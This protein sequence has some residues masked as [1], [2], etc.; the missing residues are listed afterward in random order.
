M[1]DD[2][3]GF[4]ISDILPDLPDVLLGEM[5]WNLLENAA[6]HNPKEKKEVWVEG[7]SKSGVYKL[8]VADDGPGLSASRKEAVF[9][10]RKHGGGVGLTLVSQM[11]RKYGGSIEVDDRVEGSPSLGAKFTITL[12]KPKKS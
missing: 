1:L 3:S 4:N 8:S 7:K 6:R 10:E 2:F 9:Q 11:V 5:I 12:R